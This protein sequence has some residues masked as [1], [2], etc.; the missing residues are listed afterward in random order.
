M[1]ATQDISQFIVQ[2][3]THKV[4]QDIMHYGRRC[5]INYFG[6]AFY[7]STDSSVDIRQLPNWHGTA[8]SRSSNSTCR[9]RGH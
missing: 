2:W 9:H 4:P 7:A 6:V 8:Q 1:G 3:P 5:L